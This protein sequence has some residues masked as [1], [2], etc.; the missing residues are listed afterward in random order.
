MKITLRVHNVAFNPDDRRLATVS[1]DQTTRVP[2]I[3]ILRS[4]LVVPAPAGTRLARYTSALAPTG[5]CWPE[6]TDANLP[7][8]SEVRDVNTAQKVFFLVQWG[9]LA[10]ALA[11]PLAPVSRIATAN[12]AGTAN[13]LVLEGGPA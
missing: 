12:T 1:A 6:P 2:D 13:D 4:L 3:A 8:R 11:P 10:H 7:E 9:M 5:D